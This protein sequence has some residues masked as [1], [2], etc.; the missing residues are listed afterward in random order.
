MNRTFVLLAVVFLAVGCGKKTNYSITGKLVGGSGKTIYLNRLLTTSQIPADSAKL[1]KSGEFKLKG[2]VDAPTFF[3]LKIS[4]TNFATL[5]LDSAENVIVSGSYNHFASDY[6]VKGSDN[7]SKVRELTFRLS[8]VKSKLDSISQLYKKHQNIPGYTTDMERWNNEYTKLVTD[9]TNYLNDFVKRNPF[10]MASVYALYQKWDEG[11]YVS[12]DFQTMK[13]AASALF[14]VY[15][16]NDQTKALYYN[17][18]NILKEQKNAKLN[19][20]MAQSAVNSPNI[21]LPDVSGIERDLWSLHGKCVLLHFWSA[22]DRT[23]RIQNEVLV[24][25]YAKFK[26]KGF[27]IYMVSVDDDMAAWKNAIAEDQ[28]TWINVGDMK[29]SSSAL[30]NYNIRSVPANYLLDKEGKIIGK[31]LKGPELNAALLKAL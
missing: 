27:E 1:D 28:L 6:D 18:L 24:E 29:G 7:S 30:N 21:K 31:N 13:T 5:I 16:K 10:S 15:P 8:A 22:K 14:A 23:S 25:L 17:A 26:H 20:L 11:N 9:Y 3:L 12:N 4:D 19:T 2:K